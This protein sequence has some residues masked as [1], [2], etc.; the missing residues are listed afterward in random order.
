[1]LWTLDKTPGKS[2]PVSTNAWTLDKAL[3]KSFPVTAE[4]SAI[5]MFFLSF[6]E[7]GTFGLNT[8]EMGRFLEASPSGANDEPQDL[9]DWVASSMSDFDLDH[10]GEISDEEYFDI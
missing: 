6:D 7:D 3:E 9:D 4:N 2:S 8:T 10:N 5:V 1:M